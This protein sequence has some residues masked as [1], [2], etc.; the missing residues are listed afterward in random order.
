MG[1][2]IQAR[3]VGL[4]E[5]TLKWVRRR[6]A[7]AGMLALA[8]LLLLAL[9]GGGVSLWY[10]GRLAGV[11]TLAQQAEAEAQR[12]KGIADEQRVLVQTLF[13]VNAGLPKSLLLARH[14]IEAGSRSSAVRILTG[15]PWDLRGWEWRN[16]CR[17]TSLIHTLHG[18]TNLVQS[19][20]FSP[21]GQLLA[22]ASWDRTVQLWDARTGQEI[23]T[24]QGHRTGAGRLFQ[25]G[26]AVA[27][28]CQ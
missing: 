9:V 7:L 2:P 26:W 4:A 21:D 6:P 23:H 27:G 19:V 20:C 5:W 28:E 8:L 22:S 18:H 10:S 24:M 1:E 3:P 16:L 12:H 14:E 17:G 15:C 11:L 25:P 13:D